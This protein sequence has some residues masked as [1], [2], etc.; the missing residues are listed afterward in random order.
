MEARSY[1]ISDPNQ[2]E[3]GAGIF[4][5]TLASRF[6]DDKP[7]R[8]K[9]TRKAWEAQTLFLRHLHN[10]LFMRDR[11][12]DRAYGGIIQ[13]NN[14]YQRFMTLP[15]AT[16]D[17][18]ASAFC[19]R[20]AYLTVNKNRYPVNAITWTPD[21]RRLLTGNN[22]G[23]YTIWNGRA[24]NYINI[25]QAHDTA[26]KKMVWTPDNRMLVSGDQGGIIKIWQ[27]TLSF[28]RLLP[29][30][31]IA[32]QTPI[33]GMS[34]ASTGRKLVTC[35]DEP[36]IKLWDFERCEL[37][38]SISGHGWDVKAVDWHPRQGLF[39]SGSKDNTVKLW[40]PRQKKCLNTLHSHRNTVN[41]CKW[42]KNG[43]WL[44]SGGRDQ[45]LKVHDIRIMK[46]LQTFK[47]HQKDVTCVVWHPTHE[48]VCVSAGWDGTLITW[49]VGSIEPMAQVLNAHEQT[50]W[51]ME[52]H[53]LGNLLA[54]GSNDATV[55]IW[56]RQ[57]PGDM[58]ND[59]FNMEAA[60]AEELAKKKASIVSDFSDSVSSNQRPMDK[61]KRGRGQDG[62]DR[63]NRD[64]SKKRRPNNRTGPPPDDYV[65][66]LCN[67]P[68]H[69]IQDCKFA[70]KSARDDHNPDNSNVGGAL[71]GGGVGGGIVLAQECAP[72]SS[73]SGNNRNNTSS[74]GPP[75][76]GGDSSRV[77]PPDYVC[78]RC[79][80]KGHYIADCP[81]K[82]IIP[83]PNYICFACGQGG[84][85]KQNCPLLKKQGNAGGTGGPSG[86]PPAGGA[87]P[88]GNRGSGNYSSQQQYNR[89]P[90]R[91]GRNYPR[92]GPP[93]QAQQQQASFQQ[94][95]PMGNQ[96]GSG[97]G[98]GR[99]QQSHNQPPPYA[100]QEYP[101]QQQQQQ[102]RQSQQQYNQYSQQRG[103]PPPFASP[104]RA[105]H[106]G[107]QG[108][109]GAQQQNYGGGGG[110]QNNQRYRQG[111]PPP[112]GHQRGNPR[113][114]GG[115]Q[116]RRY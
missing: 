32:H 48:R 101:A 73:S 60:D 62:D 69:W 17:Q 47:G 84:H 66:R 42:N 24:F 83:P 88:T 105:Y 77:P 92:G 29:A 100:Q 14:L 10:R 80:Q 107:Q 4:G 67:E 78:N 71:F 40:D 11:L 57:R 90:S 36:E 18:P 21:G 65:C 56:S 30:T 58:M 86:A 19:T 13:P 50:V 3:L 1:T 38:Q 12:R 112:G 23:E 114:S 28:I 9:M 46:E 49:A 74:G 108:Q 63:N 8:G 111:G 43:N 15:E 115:N 53:P 61:S 109:G 70:V 22:A 16:Q 95:G 106:Q 6:G 97:G 79:K 2:T 64:Q 91:T 116:Y 7:G 75:S 55:R 59:D 37:E 31:G 87:P 81:M 41:V 110:R 103:G 76:G 27:P 20:F 34:F 35:A 5:D 39:A 82:G 45:L 68:G 33:R 51:T 44:I 25:I 99:Y 26:I 113:Q 89:P 94:R 96:R 98:S 93:Q 104:P 102:Y 72:S 54:T 52:F 85:Y